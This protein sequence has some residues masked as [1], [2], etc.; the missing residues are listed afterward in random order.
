MNKIKGEKITETTY[1]R[2]VTYFSDGTINY[3]DWVYKSE[4]TSNKYY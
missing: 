2:K 3:G 1:E 4:K